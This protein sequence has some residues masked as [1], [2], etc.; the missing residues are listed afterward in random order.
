MNKK[1]M[2]QY[3]WWKVSYDENWS[4]SDYDLYL[5]SFG[6]RVMSSSSLGE[7]SFSNVIFSPMKIDW[8]K[9]DWMNQHFYT[10]Q[11]HFS[12]LSIINSLLTNLFLL[13]SVEIEF[14]IGKKYL[15][16]TWNEN[17]RILFVGKR[18]FCCSVNR[19]LIFDQF[20]KVSRIRRKWRRENK[21]FLIIWKKSFDY[22]LW[23]FV[24]S[25][26]LGKILSV[27]IDRFRLFCQIGQKRFSIEVV[28]KIIRHKKQ[29][30][31]EMLLKAKRRKFEVSSV[32]T[33]I[34]R[35]VSR[36]KKKKIKFSNV[37][38]CLFLYFNENVREQWSIHW[39]R[40]TT[41]EVNRST[42]IDQ[43]Q[44]HWAKLFNR[45][46]PVFSTIRR[47]VELKLARF[48]PKL[49]VKLSC[50]H[51]VFEFSCSMWRK[52]VRRSFSWSV[53]SFMQVYLARFSNLFQ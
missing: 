51:L 53:D 49:G 22:F 50:L 6:Q 33:E 41:I 39:H 27:M 31:R 47:R 24:L 32:P 34:E 44:N 2:M 40:K 14:R 16:S 12:F 3:H 8:I 4:F 25:P 7:K 11:R 19:S 37:V 18:I 42:N 9:A 36:E 20:E 48:L 21:I 45:I 52:F 46:Y 29:L 15:L 26:I 38:F 28:D 43:R 30:V 1:E 13:W 23:N 10:N 35:Y 5:K 17:L